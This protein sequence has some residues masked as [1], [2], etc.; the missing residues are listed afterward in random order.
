MK[1]PVSVPT[2]GIHK[3]VS[4]FPKIVYQEYVF[5]R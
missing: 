1:T 3:A 4:L 2:W 5:P